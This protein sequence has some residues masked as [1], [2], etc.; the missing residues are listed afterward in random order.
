MVLK[1]SNSVRLYQRNSL[2]VTKKKKGKVL[3]NRRLLLIKIEVRENT[4]LEVYK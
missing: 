3:F 2:Q 4:I 1:Y